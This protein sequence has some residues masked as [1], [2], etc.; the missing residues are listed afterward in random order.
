MYQTGAP[1]I[2]DNGL[3]SSRVNEGNINIQTLQMRKL[4]LKKDRAAFLRAT[5]LESNGAGIVIWICLIPQGVTL[6]PAGKGVEPDVGLEG[7]SSHGAR[8]L[9]PVLR[10]HGGG[11]RF[12]D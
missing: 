7:S 3:H 1:G 6:N 2:P 4:G 11:K 8:A 5:E 10:G 12:P 9:K